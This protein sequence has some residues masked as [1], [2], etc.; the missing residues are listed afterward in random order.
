[1]RIV[2]SRTPHFA[3]IY[4]RVRGWSAAA[5]LCVFIAA[6]AATSVHAQQPQL[7]AAAASDPILRALQAELTRSKAQ[8]KME[9]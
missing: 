9:N 1:M 7:P 6:S 3:L 2:I 4:R 5:I 8:L